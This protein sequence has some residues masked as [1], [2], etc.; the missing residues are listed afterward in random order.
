[1]ESQ[2]HQQIA[3]SC[4]VCPLTDSKKAR[5]SKKHFSTGIPPP[6]AL[7]AEGQTRGHAKKYR[8]WCT[9]SAMSQASGYWASAHRPVT[10][11][12]LLA[13][14]W[15]RQTNKQHTVQRQ[16]LL[17]FYYFSLLTTQETLLIHRLLNHINL[18]LIK[19]PHSEWQRL[20]CHRRTHSLFP[21]NKCYYPGIELLSG[22][23][24]ACFLR[25][26]NTLSALHYRQINC[27][28][29]AKGYQSNAVILFSSPSV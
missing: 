29:T 7:P 11:A 25:C 16:L 8:M 4:N 23:L 12:H 19:R 15:Y 17:D 22:E 6:F 1:M 3:E 27:P 2:G 18:R 5:F 20:L 26:F 13:R 24:L 14:A 10:V 28:F 21:I 9:W